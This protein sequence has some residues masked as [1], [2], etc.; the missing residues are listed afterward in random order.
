MTENLDPR[1][2]I[3]KFNLRAD[4]ELFFVF[5]YV[6]CYT[7]NGRWLEQKKKAQRIRIP[8]GVRWWYANL[9]VINLKISLLMN[10]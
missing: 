9:N 10:R 7:L 3:K 4:V 8:D 1:S 6:N 5:V 2:I